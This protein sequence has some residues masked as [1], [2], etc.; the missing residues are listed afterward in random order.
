MTNLQNISN[1]LFNENHS[2]NQD[3]VAW[4]EVEVQDRIEDL[5]N[6][7]DE[8][9]TNI[10][11]LISDLEIISDDVTALKNDVENLRS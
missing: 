3:N 11:N 7:L 10:I 1:A 5:Y 8:V 6:D 9:E 2:Q 4:E